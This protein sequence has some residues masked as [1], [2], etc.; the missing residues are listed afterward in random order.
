[1]KLC[2]PASRTHSLKPWTP[3]AGVRH[4]FVRAS[5]AKTQ[6]SVPIKFIRSPGLKNQSHTAALA[7]EATTSIDA[8]EE[9]CDE[10]PRGSSHF[11]ATPRSTCTAPAESSVLLVLLPG[12]MLEPADYQMLTHRI[13]ERGSASIAVWVAN[14]YP[15]WQ[16]LDWGA[17]DMQQQGNDRMSGALQAVMEEAERQGFKPTALSTG[18]W[19]NMFIVSHSSATQFAATLAFKQA[20]GLILLGSYLFPLVTSWGSLYEWSRPVLHLGGLRDGQVR[21]TRFAM[22]A[23]Q[24]ADCA[25]R[26]GT[27]YTAA[28][29]PVILLPGIN[30]GH[31]SN[32]ETRTQSGDLEADISREAA[33]E[34][35]ADT[36]VAFLK[37]HGP[38]SIE[39]KAKALDSLQQQCIRTAEHL[40]PFTEA[41][42]RGSIS[43]AW[44]LALEHDNDNMGPSASHD[45]SRRYIAHPSELSML[46]RFA[47]NLQ[48]RVIREAGLEDSFRRVRVMA[49]V[50]VDVDSFI[51]SQ[52]TTT[53]DYIMIQAYLYRPNLVP[54][55]HR[56]PMAPHYIL[57]IKSARGLAEAY[58]TGHNITCDDVLASQIHEEDME[59]ALGM[60]PEAAR[61]DFEAR[62]KRWQC[63]LDR[64]VLSSIKSPVQWV[65]DMPIELVDTGPRTT[66]VTSPVLKPQSSN[67]EGGGRFTGSYYLKCLSLAAA[68]EWILCDG[69]R[70]STAS[71]GRD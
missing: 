70:P 37:L 2:T 23:L 15:V 54:Y 32:G 8:E 30:H 9:F 22:P 57:K 51:Y 47:V 60:V 58:D 45:S 19:E 21:P 66:Q 55:G 71:D 35:I 14:V 28:F 42:G 4:R 25:A 63:A 69:L 6:S 17:A 44:K 46:E 13:Q 68:V 53:S 7:S 36:I 27:R 5:A 40:S 52:P 1:M 3:A 16:S 61:A 10:I 38:D 34:S 59:Q 39:G 67:R 49:T 26:F 64:D 12:A 41:L 11:I 20:G 43:E 48:W 56:I 18:R 33:A 31:M 24:S 50:H 29:K 62:G 65:K